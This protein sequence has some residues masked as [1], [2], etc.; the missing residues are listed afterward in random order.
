MSGDPTVI[1]FPEGA[2][3]PTNNCVG[4]GQV[5]RARG[6]R[7]VF[8]VEESFAGTLEEQGFEERLMR[9]KPP[10]EVEEAPGQFWKDFVRETAPEFRRPTL[11]QL[12]GFVLPVWRELVDGA[13]YV[14]ERLGEI[15]AEVQPDVI[16][17]DNV[18]GF[19]AVLASARPWVRIVSCNPLELKDPDL[20]PTFSGYPA[21]DRSGWEEFLERYRALHEPLQG[22]FSDFCVERGAPPLPEGEFIH[23]SAFLNLYL[24]PAEADYQRGRPLVPT[25]HRLDSCVRDTREAL[26][27]AVDEALARPPEGGALLYLSLGSLGSADVGLMQRLLDV[28]G[29]TRHH[30]IVS[31]GPQH[32]E[33]RLPPNATG[34]E[35]LPQPAI[36]P[37][38]DLV[39]SHGGNN[40]VTESLQFGKPLLVLPLFWDQHDNAQRID[41]L[42]LGARLAPYHVEPAELTES[43]DRLLG[44][45]PLHERLRRISRRLRADPGTRRAAELIAAVASSWE[46]PVR[47]RQ[48][49]G[50]RPARAPVSDGGAACACARRAG[51]RS[52]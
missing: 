38:V 30:L 35:F 43:I 16:V 7:V 27:A 17:E 34:A 13:R 4:I 44:D 19:P 20:P 41:E 3:G 48:A 52:G 21:A 5:L 45:H 15:F 24:Y 22:E 26:D 49:R 50:L 31:M 46:R 40:T 10:L 32:T 37:K 29:E 6:A 51:G 11:E 28:L 14:N 23:A 39:I 8:V 47:D 36:L 18:V 42:G 9:L 25:W 33:L 1:F 12:E 2:F